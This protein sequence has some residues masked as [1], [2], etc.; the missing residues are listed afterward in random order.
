MKT[1][2]LYSYF[3]GF[4]QLK[5]SLSKMNDLFDEVVICYQ[6]VSNTGNISSD[7]ESEIKYIQTKYPDIHI[8]HFNPNLNINTKQ[9]ELT[10]HNQLLEY[11][12]ELNATHFVISAC[13]HVYSKQSLDF[14]KEKIKDFDVVLT[15]MVTYYKCDEWVLFPLESYCMPFLHRLY[16]NTQFVYGL[17]YPVLVDP[18]VKV[19]TS[20][21]IYVA[22][23]Y[24]CIMHHYSMVRND[25]KNK[26]DNA[27][28]SVNWSD[29]L[30]DTF[31]SEYNNAKIGDKLTY[32]KGLELVHVDKLR[33][34]G[35]IAPNE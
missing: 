26:F 35:I 8:T 9:N 6:T 17:K 11:A 34:C 16:D 29:E 15:E 5:H 21:K 19:N 25:I 1:V 4:E 12:K 3:N 13:D 30:I 33:E 32:F 10:K 20:S 31:I 18:S 14:A 24:E 27:A 28:S 22:K 2:L 23:S 7:I